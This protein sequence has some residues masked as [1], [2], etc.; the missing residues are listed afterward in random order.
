MIAARG[1]RGVIV[2]ADALALARREPV[3]TAASRN[4]LPSVFALRDFVDAGGL[5][6][7]GAVWTDVFRQAA[8]LVDR[9]LRGARPADLPV[10]R[11]SRFELVVNLRTARAIPLPIPLPFLRRA[12]RVIQCLDGRWRCPPPR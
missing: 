9:I 8:G 6:S 2:R 11:A 1:R 12:G 3:A 5:I 7:Y 10:A 4:R